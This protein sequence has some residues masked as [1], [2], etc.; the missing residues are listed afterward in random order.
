ML[1]LRNLLIVLAACALA[2]MA[3]AA[4]ISRTQTSP[5]SVELR[6]VVI[7]GSERM[8]QLAHA[9]RIIGNPGAFPLPSLA[10]IAATIP[11]P[12]LGATFAGVAMLGFAYWTRRLRS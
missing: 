7:R 4:T 8:D 10:S 5:S 11:E 3:T 2:A 9:P 6:E 12:P 1:L